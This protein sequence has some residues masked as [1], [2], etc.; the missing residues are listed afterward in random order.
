MPVSGLLGWLFDLWLAWGWRRTLGGFPVHTTGRTEFPSSQEFLGEF[1]RKPMNSPR[2]HQLQPEK[3]HPLEDLMIK[4]YGK[5]VFWG[6]KCIFSV[7]E[8]WGQKRALKF[9]CPHRHQAGF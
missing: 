9:A 8:M 3:R 1:F 6:G 5:P 7:Y 2:E 4:E